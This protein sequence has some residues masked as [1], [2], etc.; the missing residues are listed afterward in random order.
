MSVEYSGAAPGL[1]AGVTQLNI[2]L[3]DPIPLLPPSV[4]KGLVPLAVHFDLS[5]FT[6]V[7]T[8]AVQ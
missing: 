7:V 3:P 5:E 4:P 6:N 2:R 8:V 1:L